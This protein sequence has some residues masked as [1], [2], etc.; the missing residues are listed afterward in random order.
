VDTY[1][2]HDGTDENGIVGTVAMALRSGGSAL[3]DD[4]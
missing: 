3:A 1:R 4:L 2:I